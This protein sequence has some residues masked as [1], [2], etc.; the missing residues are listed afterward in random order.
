LSILQ[1]TT[2]HLR[3]PGLSDIEPITLER[4]K[5]N[6]LITPLAMNLLQ[7]SDYW[8]QDMNVKHESISSLLLIGGSSHIPFLR[9]Q[10][11]TRYQR[12]LL[13]IDLAPN[14]LI[15]AGASIMGSHEEMRSNSAVQEHRPDEPPV[16]SSPKPPKNYNPR[17]NP[18]DHFKKR[19]N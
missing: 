2:L 3:I 15:C 8:L 4:E 12:A 14:L 9:Q 13:E 11:A 16:K 7:C 6:K 5:F 17:E 1:R 19:S 10:F 18:F